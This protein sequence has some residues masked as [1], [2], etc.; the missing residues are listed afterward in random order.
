M[1]S[2]DAVRA[3]NRFYTRQIGALAEHH[4]ESPFSLTDMRVLYEL[5]HRDAPTATGL[6]RDLG[7]DAGYLSRILRRFETRGLLGRTPSSA[8]A[9]QRLLGLTRKGRAAFAPLEARARGDVEALLGRLA[10]PEQ[11]QVVDAMGT[12]ERLLGAPRA[13]AAR[14]ESYLLRAHQAGDMGWVVHRHAAM[15]AREWGYN[16]EFEALVARICADFLDHF[17]PAGE[18][19]WMA[20]RNG[21]IVGS[22]FVVRKSK[23][24]AKLRLLL[25]EPEARGLGIGRRLIDECIRFARQAGYRR[26]TLW[27]QSDLDAA[28]RLYQRAGF[29]RVHKKSHHAFGRTDLVAETWDLTLSAPRS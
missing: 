6:G 14:A 21:D 9:R 12:I 19:C 2:V 29:R 1:S 18:R 10:G 24:V 7:L 25:V 16:A 4:L 22:V 17:D 27:T 3:F 8:D 23:T 28:R 26:L 5:A 13:E 15:Y 11:R 20:E